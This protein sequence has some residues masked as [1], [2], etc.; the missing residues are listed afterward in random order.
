MSVL[1]SLSQNSSVDDWYVT[2]RFFE[3]FFR[4]VCERYRPNQE[5]IELLTRAQLVNGIILD[6]EAE[7]DITRTRSSVECL[8][9]I[10]STIANE[11]DVQGSRQTPNIAHE[12]GLES[13][14]ELRELFEPLVKL[15][16]K[17][18][19]EYRPASQGE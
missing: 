4:V 8:L 2:N 6:D 18:Q 10:L 17:W 12:L 7:E 3:L 15:C 1:I 14:V 13:N 19:H 9:Q 11:I 5:L 16:I